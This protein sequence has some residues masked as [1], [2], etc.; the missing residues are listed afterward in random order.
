MTLRELGLQE[1]PDEPCLFTND[2]LILF[3]Y[4]DDIVALCHKEHLPRLNAFECD[5]KA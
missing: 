3:F 2:W 5:L 1:V 4:V